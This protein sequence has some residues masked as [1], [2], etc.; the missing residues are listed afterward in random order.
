M[1][2]AKVD[3][4]LAMTALDK[5]LK[6]NELNFAMLAAI[7]S[8]LFVGYVFRQTWDVLASREQV[9]KTAV[10][11]YI[12][13]SLRQVERILLKES[14]RYHRLHSRSKKKALLKETLVSPE[15]DNEDHLQQQ[16]LLLSCEEQGMLLCEMYA[17]RMFAESLPARI[18]GLFVNDLRGLERNVPV[19]RRLAAV[20]RMWRSYKFL[21]IE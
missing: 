5:L 8:L 15:E 18:A 1:Q 10:Y 3:G 6:S 12:R 14:P 17:M 11:T 4:E 13:L 9:S 21:Q 7:P 2:K 19:V 16:Q 20:D